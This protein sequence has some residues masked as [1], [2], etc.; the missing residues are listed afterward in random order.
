MRRFLLAGLASTAVTSFVLAQ[1]GTATPTPQVFGP[2]DGTEVGPP[3]V[4]LD[5]WVD[6]AFGGT[7][8][9]S[10]G[11]PFTTVPAALAAVPPGTN[12]TINVTGPHAVALVMPSRGV[13]LESFSTPTSVGATFTAAGPAPMITIA[14]EGDVSLRKSEIRGITFTDT[15][16]GPPTDVG[17]LVAPGALTAEAG[18][19]VTQCTF[20]NL[21][22]G[23][24]ITVAPGAEVAKHL[25]YDNHFAFPFDLEPP[26]SIGATAID[27]VSFGVSSTLVRAN[28]ITDYE[29]GVACAAIAGGTAQPRI[30]SNTIQDASFGAV[31]LGCDSD[32]RSN[33]I[34]FGDARAAPAVDGIQQTGGTLSLFNNILW[35]PPAPAVATADLNLMG[36]AVLTEAFNFYNTPPAGTTPVPGLVP[37]FVGTPIGI[38]LVDLHL[39]PGSAMIDAGSSALTASFATPLYPILVG[40][41]GVSRVDVANDIDQDPRIFG[42]ATDVG[43][44]ELVVFTDPGTGAV[45]PLTLSLG[46][47]PAL[48]GSGATWDA[49]GNMYPGGTP[50]SP[51][52]EVDVVVTGP[53]NSVA[54]LF[55]G[56]VYL[57]PAG[58]APGP[59]FENGH[60]LHHS[61]SPWGNLFWDTSPGFHAQVFFVILDATGVGTGT[62][63][64]G[65]LGMDNIES[66][67]MVQATILGNQGPAD[68]AQSNKLLL[69]INDGAT[70]GF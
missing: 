41:N 37:G 33:T 63:N 24:A 16:F 47:S 49:F 4:R 52:W 69:E 44:D 46:A 48:S 14:A 9:G 60:K 68:L 38:G 59:F 66:E 20:E 35:N 15:P 34:A 3:V 62:I 30:Q 39:A 5:L 21:L 54:F 65:A 67:V 43:S 32:V 27:I 42:P 28:D 36:G 53:P 22:T 18:V 58:A 40:S 50:G 55:E 12:T 45:T 31:L 10:F 1:G 29:T 61:L 51:I 13:C 23:V 57:D 11:Q 8:T 6:P 64:Y 2:W 26:G 25:V 19:R 7:S 70:T 56:W 17:I